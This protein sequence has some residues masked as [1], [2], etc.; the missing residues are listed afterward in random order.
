[1]IVIADDISF[2]PH[3]LEGTADTLF[4]FRDQLFVLLPA[5]HRLESESVIELA[6]LRDEHWALD[7]ACGA[8]SMAIRQNL[9][10]PVRASPKS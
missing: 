4:L 3:T 1:D 6:Q 8:Y 7:V 9:E 2:D 5:G 10:A